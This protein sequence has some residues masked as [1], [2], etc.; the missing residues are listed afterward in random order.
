MNKLNFHWL[1]LLL[2]SGLFPFHLVAWW[3]LWW[4][5]NQDQP[6]PH[7]TPNQSTISTQ[8]LL[9]TLLIVKFPFGQIFPVIYDE[10]WCYSI[11]RPSSS[12]TTLQFICYSF[13][14]LFFFVI[15]VFFFIFI[16]WRFNSNNDDHHHF[17][18]FHLLDYTF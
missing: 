9:N 6:W 7:L 13:P 18:S 3:Q 16:I 10:I 17:V 15:V 4:H 2:L 12:I 11:L 8:V 14:S 5:E 1:L